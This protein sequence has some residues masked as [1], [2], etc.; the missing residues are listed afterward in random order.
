MS[1]PISPMFGTTHKDCNF[2]V[3][4]DSNKDG[5][6]SNLWSK[7]IQHKVCDKLDNLRDSVVNTKQ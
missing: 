6:V 1:Q 5:L 3:G 4:D 2:N 7:L